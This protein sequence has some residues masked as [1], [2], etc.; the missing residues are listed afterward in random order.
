[1]R[2]KA[3]FRGAEPGVKLGFVWGLIILT[4]SLAGLDLAEASPEA[5]TAVAATVAADWSSAA[6]SVVSV[7]PVGG[8]RSA[9]ND[10]V[11]SATSDISVVSEGEHFY[12]L[13]RFGAD[14]VTKFHVDSPSSPLW[15]FSVRGDET[16]A[17][18]HDLVFLSDQKA[19]L[20]RY[21]STR[22]WIVN[23]SAAS[24]AGFKIGELD[25]SL[26]ADSDGLPE[27]EGGVIVNDKLFIIM[28]RFDRDNNWVPSNTAYAAVF[29]TTTDAEIDTGQ[30]SADGLKGI[31]L[32]IKNPVSIQH[33]SLN[34]LI[35]IAGPGQYP[36]TWSD[37]TGYEYTGGILSL[38]PET[39]QTT[40]ILDDGDA[41]DHPYGAFAGLAVASPT[42]GYFVGYAGWGDNTLYTFDPGRGVVT[43]AVAGLENKNITG[44]ESGI[45]FDRNG[46]LWVCDQTEAQVVIVKTADDTVDETVGTDLNPA[47]VV[48]CGGSAA[49]DAAA[50]VSRFFEEC[51]QRGPAA[52]EINEWIVNLLAKSRTG[53]DLAQA[54]ILSQQF[55]ERGVSDEEFVVILHRTLLVREPSEDELRRWINVLASGVSREAILNQFTRADEFAHVCA[56]Y[57]VTPY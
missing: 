31:P 25:L 54:F 3:R 19:Y 16:S 43:G 42:K 37:P 13:A 52:T 9:Q 47:K 55:E 44:M 27:M 56:R 38:D 51:W 46:M 5:Q 33:L 49:D 45:Y 30:G 11:P 15:Q 18:P 22:A 24:E 36:S 8:P 14:S 40:F 12:R 23:P 17:N 1:M 32:P 50:F 34:N 7:G 41:N 26:Y 28:Q 57:G 53:A 39:Y 4:G 6:H 10:L 2:V 20:L 35:Y 29:D 21:G 48:F